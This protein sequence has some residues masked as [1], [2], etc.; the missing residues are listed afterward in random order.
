MPK[1]ETCKKHPWIVFVYCIMCD[2][3][4]CEVCHSANATSKEHEMAIS[5]TLTIPGKLDLGGK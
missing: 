3:Q 4:V 5:K 1:S 2:K